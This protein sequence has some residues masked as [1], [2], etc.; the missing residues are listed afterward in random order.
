MMR[1]E[2]PG[3][4]LKDTFEALESRTNTVQR[5]VLDRVQEKKRMR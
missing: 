3:E 2:F 4:N 1:L 5:N